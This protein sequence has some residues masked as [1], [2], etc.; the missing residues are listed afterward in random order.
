MTAGDFNSDGKVD[1]AIG[2]GKLSILPGKGDGTFSTH[3]DYDYGTGSVLLSLTAGDFNRDGGLDLAAGAITLDSVGTPK[4]SAV[5]VLL[6]VSVVALFPNVLSFGQESLGS[7]SEPETILLSNPSAAPVQISRISINGADAADFAETNTCDSKV[8]PGGNCNVSVTFTPTASGTRTAALTISDDALARQQVI[9]LTGTSSA[10]IPRV[11]LDPT[12]IGFGHQLVGTASAPQK[13]TLTNTGSGLLEISGIAVHGDFAETNTCGSTVPADGA[14]AIS[15]TFTPTTTGVRTGSLTLTDNNNGVPG[16]VQTVTLSGT[17]TDFTIS[18][19]P[20]AQTIPSGHKA[21]Y[22]ITLMSVSG[23]T[24]SV[25]LACS[26]GPPNSTCTLSP[27]SVMLAGT[28]TA[29]GTVTL[30]P[31]M[32]VNHGTFTLTFTASSDGRNHNTSVSLTVK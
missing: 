31:P 13:V 7:S 14:C 30:L 24:G 21:A 6:N 10:S 1:L 18:A 4:A 3:I 19:T 17:G 28:S 11:R 8:L 12:S 26:G 29:K 27:S 25:S 15:I 16:S 5:S 32:N 23:F 2:G 20:A 22:T 9:S